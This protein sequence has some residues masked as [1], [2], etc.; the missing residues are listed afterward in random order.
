LIDS[1]AT[2][3][4]DV[5]KFVGGGTPSRARPEHFQGNIPWATV[6]DF[7][8]FVLYD[9]EEHI[10]EA[11][12][13]ASAV[14]VVDAGTVLL[15]SRVGLGKVAMAGVRLA[16]NQDIKGLTPSPNVL[17]EFLFWFL[18]YKADSIKQMGVGATVKGIT[19][20]DIRAIE[21][22]IPSLD[23]QRRIVDILFR[24]EGII[25][26]RREAE[27]KAAELI[28]AL[29]LELIGDPA[30]N[31][32]GLATATVGDVVASVDY[33]SSTKATEDGSG[34]PFI[35]MNNVDYAGNFNLT[36]L[37]YA[38]LSPAEIV[39]FGLREGDILFNRTNSK[40]LVGKTGIWDDAREA[41]AASY[42]I[43]VRVDQNKISPRFFWAFMNS[44]HMKRVLFD[45]A[46]GAIGQANINSK[47]LKAFSIFVPPLDLQ[48]EFA[49]RIEQ[50]RSIQS[51][52]SAATAKAQATFDALLARC[53]KQPTAE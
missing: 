51:Q 18:V 12:V 6:K 23:S 7:K 27:K 15:V 19:L 45:T 22:P 44:A 30:T 50:I 2:R 38:E 40:E 21:I 48:I 31:P 37:K 9:T 53:F 4:G 26:L 1:K 35:R 46:R 16:I 8:R 32:K 5:C 11:A 36:N 43:R 39:R 47:E 29:F 3:L 20:N 42:F 52:Q 24:A 28:P 25:R 41:V 49:E 13:A 14:N 10:N 34:V 33:G 17:P